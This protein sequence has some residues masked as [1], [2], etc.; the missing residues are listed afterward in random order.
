M[1]GSGAAMRVH[2]GGFVERLWQR[3]RTEEVR[4]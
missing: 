3:A 2:I 4:R 1:T